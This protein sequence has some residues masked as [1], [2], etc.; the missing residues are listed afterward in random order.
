MPKILM[1]LAILA[2]VAMVESR[3]SSDIE[4]V[5][6]VGC[7]PPENITRT[8]RCLRDIILG[9]RHFVDNLIFGRDLSSKPKIIQIGNGYRNNN[10]V[11]ISSPDGLYNYEPHGTDQ[12][13]SDFS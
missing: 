3:P 1:C 10:K 2:V 7:N 4:K 8:K 11:Y 12:R 6:C 5:P 13:Y 9:M